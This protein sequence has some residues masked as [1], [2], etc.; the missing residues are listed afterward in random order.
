M[1]P[2]SSLQLHAYIPASE[3]FLPAGRPQ[4][5]VG[6]RAC[7]GR[8]DD[9]ARL[10]ATLAYPEKGTTRRPRL[11][12]P[13]AR[14]FQAASVAVPVALSA[15]VAGAG[16]AQRLGL[17]AAGGC[18]LLQRRPSCP[19]GNPDDAAADGDDDDDKSGNGRMGGGAVTFHAQLGTPPVPPSA[20]LL[21]RSLDALCIMQTT[22]V[23]SACLPIYDEFKNKLNS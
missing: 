18:C 17:D 15:T 21:L 14:I 2:I 1:T 5:A 6:R 8:R 3:L 9:A 4:W 22:V 11:T 23:Y 13:L 16:Q 10:A 20:G 19:G 12:A 7:H